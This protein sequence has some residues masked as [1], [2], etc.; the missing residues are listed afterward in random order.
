MRAWLGPVQDAIDGLLKGLPEAL[1]PDAT[2]TD[3]AETTLKKR[4]KAISTR[5][6]EIY[7]AMD[8]SRLE[9][10]LVAAMATGEANGIAE[11]S[12]VL[13]DSLSLADDDKP[14]LSRPYSVNDAEAWLERQPLLPTTLKS[15]EISDLLEP[16]LRN[17]A[18][19]SAQ[20]S[21]ANIL[22]SLKQATLDV[23][24]GRLGYGE[25]IAKLNRFLAAEGYGIP[26]PNSSAD[27]DLSTLAS[28]ARLN[29]VLRQNTAMAHAVGQRRVSEDPGVMERWPNYRYLA[30]TDRHQ[31]FDN[32][33]L[34]K[35][36]PFWQ[37]HY[38]PWDFRCQCMVIDE[39]GEPN[40]KAS[41]FDGRGTAGRVALPSG[42]VAELE[43]PESGFVFASSPATAF[44]EL[45]YGLIEDAALRAIALGRKPETTPATTA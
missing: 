25:A 8:T 3:A 9:D 45:D 1:D 18:F 14:F 34:P 16:A 24:S 7:R 38:P 19:F 33:V 27:K 32:L 44:A 40:G 17:Q 5:L 30:N 39:D 20:V 26:D 10:A 41:G 13:A 2:D 43:E 28:L 35:T 42:Q 4:C 22:A 12:R 21:S 36:D 23:A 37:T 6:P 31:K 15:R 29:L 11:R